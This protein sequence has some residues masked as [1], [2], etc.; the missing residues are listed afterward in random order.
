MAQ[1]KWLPNLEVA[2]FPMLPV[3]DLRTSAVVP[4]MGFRGPAYIGATESC[5]FDRHNHVSV[6]GQSWDRTSFIAE[7]ALLSKHKHEVLEPILCFR[8]ILSQQGAC[9]LD[10]SDQRGRHGVIILMFWG[11]LRISPDYM[12]SM[13]CRTFYI[14]TPNHKAYGCR[15]EGSSFSMPRKI[16]L[17]LVFAVGTDARPPGPISPFLVAERSAGIIHLHKKL[18]SKCYSFA[19]LSCAGLGTAK[20]DSEPRS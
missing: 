6:G 8:C 13:P 12:Y 15:R 11:P 14:Y 7:V 10:S 18:T 4:K 9:L 17:L 19:N 5:C 16:R 3:V 1:H 2:N 20:L